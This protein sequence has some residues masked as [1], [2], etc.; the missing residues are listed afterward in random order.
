[1]PDT[2]AIPWPRHRDQYETLAP[3]YDL[4]IPDPPGMNERYVEAARRYGVRGP[5]LEVGAGTGR[6]TTRLAAAGYEVIAFDLSLPMLAVL[7]LKQRRLPPEQAVRIHRVQGDQAELRLPAPFTEH[8]FDMI[9]SPG[10]TLQHATS[11]SELDAIL[12]CHA[13]RLRPGGILALDVAGTPVPQRAGAYVE[14]YPDTTLAHL[15][16]RWAR[17]ESWNESRFDAARGLTHTD[18]RFRMADAEGRSTDEFC[19]GFEY[20][21]LEPGQLHDALARAGLE[22]LE[23]HGD[24]LG[25]P[26][27]ERGGDL[28]M[29]ARAPR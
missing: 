17:V 24:F 29:I 22:L 10:G 4:L 7:E 5:I 13:R 23:S 20:T 14:R 9:I 28:V 21:Y 2:S 6:L 26:T 19:F 16:P 27:R 8:R 11:K 18:C 1:M 15:S 12:A 3:V 25:G